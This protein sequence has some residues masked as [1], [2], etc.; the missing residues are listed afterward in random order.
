MSSLKINKKHIKY[1]I[2]IILLY[3]ILFV[4]FSYNSI[5]IFIQRLIGLFLIIPIILDYRTIFKRLDKKALFII[6][7]YLSFVI[8]SG[9]V[10][11]HLLNYTKPFWGSLI[12]SLFI[13]DA[14]FLFTI[15]IN[16]FGFKFLFKSLFFISFLSIFINDLFILRGGY[17]LGKTG[18]F[19]LGNKFVVSYKHL[20]FLSLYYMIS[21]QKK[22][23]SKYSSIYN[24][25]FFIILYILSFFIII[26]IGSSTGIVSLI[27]LLAFLLLAAGNKVLD[28]KGYIIIL[29][30]SGSFTFFAGKFVQLTYIKYAIT[31][32]LG[33]DL[34]LTGRLD[35]FSLIPK[36]LSGHL[37]FGYGYGSS[38]EVWQAKTIVYPNS[39]NGIIDC[40]VEQGVIATLLLLIFFC[41]C[42]FRYS[43]IKVSQNKYEIRDLN[44]MS[45]III[46]Y[47]IISSVE[48]TI[49]LN[50]IAWIII[51][52]LCAN[53]VLE[54]EGSYAKYIN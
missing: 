22:D 24:K 10:N 27:I 28:I 18:Q 7:T 45:Y 48:I 25:I 9:L 51:L 20:E 32:L 33:K 31:N 37:I 4:N 52:L 2:Y 21:N 40:I 41:Y 38:Y 17:F 53:L 42:F 44:I 11:H 49:G 23:M 3:N 26:K 50:Y 47:T 14:F 39:Q 15:I 5:F 43:K 8:I 34:S 36:V 19:F 13:L 29:L 46:I 6:L 16:K 30:I 35:I 12:Y 54:V 1:F